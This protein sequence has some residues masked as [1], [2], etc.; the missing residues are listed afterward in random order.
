MI[1]LGLSYY[2][3]KRIGHARWR[4]IHRFTAVAWILGLVHTFAEGTDAGK[5]WFIALVGLT[6][7]PAMV[8][9]VERLSRRSRTRPA[10]GGERTTRVL[11][12][13]ISRS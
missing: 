12:T 10:S 13:G 3:R 6:A 7:A 5:L 8:L 11:S 4:V 1:V 9:L 2:A